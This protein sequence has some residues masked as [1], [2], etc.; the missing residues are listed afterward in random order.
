MY[1][2]GLMLGCDVRDVDQG[3]LEAVT[4]KHLAAGAAHYR[5]GLLRWQFLAG[6]PHCIFP[7]GPVPRKSGLKIARD[8]SPEKASCESPSRCATP[9]GFV[10]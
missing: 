8:Y 1:L 6:F 5:A 3:I 9:A 4:I 10:K 2:T 7:F